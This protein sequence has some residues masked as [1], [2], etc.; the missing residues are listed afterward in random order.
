LH[1]AEGFGL[2]MAEA[3][4]LGKPTIATG[5]SGNL[6]FMSPDNSYLVGWREGTVPAGCRPYREG[7]KWAEP[8]L[9]EAASLLRRVYE[10]P[11]EARRVGEVAR[12]DLARRHSPAARAQLLGELLGRIREERMPAK[13]RPQSR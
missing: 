8:D 5:Y 6:E 1:R 13:G 10:R 7:L 9:D 12:A 11:E 2:T 4:A 3:M